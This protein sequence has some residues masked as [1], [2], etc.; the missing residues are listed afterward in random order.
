MMPA[1]RWFSLI[2]CGVALSGPVPAAAKPKPLPATLYVKLPSSNLL[3]VRTVIAAL[4]RAFAERKEVNL[5]PI[6]HLLEPVGQQLEH[7]SA[8]DKLAKQGQTNLENLEIEKGIAAFNEA[9]TRQQRVFHLISTS[10][11]GIKDHAALLGD[12]SIAHFLGG[13]EKA[14]RD[15]M[16]RALVLDSRLEYDKKRYPPQMK[17][18]F[19]E[20]RFLVDELG[21]GDVH[22]NTKPQRAEVR[23]NGEF[24]GYSPI[25]VKGLTAGFNLITVSKPGYR[26]RTVPGRVEGG[27]IVPKIEVKLRAVKGKP[28]ATLWQALGEARSGATP[29][30]LD[31]AAHYLRQKVLFL[32]EARGG[33]DQITVQIH[34]YDAKRR[35]TSS[36]IKAKISSHDPDPGC[37]RLVAS[38]MPFLQ[39]PKIVQRIQPVQTGSWFN[40]FRES[41]LF[42]PAVG[43]GAAVVAASVGIGIYY[44]T[45]EEPDRGRQLLLLPVV[46]LGR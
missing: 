12:L 30:A 25:R 9:V 43:V 15:T 1:L 16:Q 3:R 24:V 26:T 22:V 35:R 27:S 4:E 34:V 8:A 10:T 42:W 11:S 44:G 40:R 19:D 13:D 46:P 36:H 20:V 7:L 21:T 18:L 33:S 6:R 39:P 23:A 2:L 5:T 32:A 17:R 45:R 41:K 38:L 31:R 28:A 14:S 29:K 37:E